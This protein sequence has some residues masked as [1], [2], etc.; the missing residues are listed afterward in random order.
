MGFGLDLAPFGL[1]LGL[2]LSASAPPA[3]YSRHQRCNAVTLATPYLAM[4]S[5]LVIPPST[6]SRAAATFVSQSYLLLPLLPMTASSPPDLYSLI[7][8]LAVYAG[9]ASRPARTPLPAP[10]L[11]SSNASRR[12]PSS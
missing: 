2:G 9:M 6:R 8:F 12:N 11:M 1:P 5:V 7:Q 10:A 4:T 3:R